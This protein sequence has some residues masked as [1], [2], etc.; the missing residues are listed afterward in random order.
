MKIAIINDTHCGVRNSAEIFL[1]NADEFYDN[2]FF[3][4][5]IEHNIKQIIHLGD[6]YDQRKFINFKA[7]NQNRKSFLNKLREHEIEM[8]IIPGN[9]DVFYKN[10]NDLNSLKELLGHFMDEI[11]IVMEPTVKTF[12]GLNIALVPWINTENHDTT[13]E[14]IKTCKADILGGHLELNGFEVLKG[15]RH[16]HGMDASPFSRF[17]MVM[18]GHFHTKSQKDNI[19]Y[20]GSQM[21]FFWGDAHDPKFFH[22]LDTS[23]RELTPI[24]NPHTLFEK[25][26]YDDLSD[27]DYDEYPFKNLNNKFVKVIVVNKTDIFKFDKFVDKIQSRKIHELKIAENF[28]EFIGE[29]VD[30]DKVSVEDTSTLLNSYIEAAETVLD[31]NK[32]KSKMKNLLSEAQTLE[33]A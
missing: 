32:I 5:L 9:H 13:L 14:F 4:Y 26:Y 8:M 24:H 2:V 25:I 27:F 16:K 11:E 23:T 31:K 19:Y 20:L 10:T 18:S 17:E 30:D 29:N 12:D 15:I 7:L 22:V 6:Y 28:S 33:I 3:P 1:N 21:E